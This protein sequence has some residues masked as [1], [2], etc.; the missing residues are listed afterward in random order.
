[1]EDDSEL[2]TVHLVY[3]R[4]PT[5]RRRHQDSETWITMIEQ[6]LSA[7]FKDYT[8]TITQSHQASS[9][10]VTI[11]FASVDDAVWFKMRRN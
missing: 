3:P 7:D 2:R 9:T 11:V 5:D 10:E 1:M 8:V 4:D 6:I